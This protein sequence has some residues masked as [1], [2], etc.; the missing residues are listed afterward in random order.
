MSTVGVQRGH[1][2]L[3][4]HSEVKSLQHKGSAW[5]AH[6]GGSLQFNIVYKYH[7]YAILLYLLHLAF[8]ITCGLK[9]LSLTLKLTCNKKKVYF[10][11]MARRA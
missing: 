10:K 11:K 2:G 8:Y 5:S 1:G 6:T 4:Q 3:T 9:L 7:Y